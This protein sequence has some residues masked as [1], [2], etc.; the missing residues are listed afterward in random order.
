MQNDKYMYLFIGLCF[1]SAI[2]QI[3]VFIILVKRDVNNKKVHRLYR[4]LY[5]VICD[6]HYV[7]SLCGEIKNLKKITPEE[8]DFLFNH[9]KSQKPNFFK[10]RIFYLNNSS[11]GRVYWWNSLTTQTSTQQRK[12]FIKMLVDKTNTNKLT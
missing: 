6:K 9:F 2:I 1:L 10:H 12:L 11:R 3:I 7:G 8:I 4:I 5:D